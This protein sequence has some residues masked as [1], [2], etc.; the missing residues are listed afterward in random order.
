MME[1]LFRKRQRKAICDLVELTAHRGR[2]EISIVHDYESG[3]SS[4]QSEF[5]SHRDEIQ[6]RFDG[7]TLDSNESYDREKNR[8]E[9][10]IAAKE[11][12][13]ELEH[14]SEC[15]KIRDKSRSN[16]QEGEKFRHLKKGEERGWTVRIQQDKQGAAALNIRTERFYLKGLKI[17]AWAKDNDNRGIIRNGTARS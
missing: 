15:E 12:R 2:A 1:E 11:K 10:E 13:A 3:I 8:I 9:K 4:N 14:K 7:D 5:K 16:I 17:C 6:R